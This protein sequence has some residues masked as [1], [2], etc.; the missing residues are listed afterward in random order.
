VRKGSGGE[1][2]YSGFTVKHV[3]SGQD[4]PTDL[5]DL[6][7]EKGIRCVVIAGLATD[8]CVKE[9]AIDAV[10]LGFEVSVRRGAVR[11]VNLQPGDDQRSFEAMAEAGVAVV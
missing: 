2:G 8:Y 5:E 4:R 10:R 6:L 11:A 3:P 9:T 1:D 7:R